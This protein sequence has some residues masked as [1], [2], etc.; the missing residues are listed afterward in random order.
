MKILGLDLGQKTLGIAISDRLLI[1][2]YGR[3]TVRFPR[4]DFSLA[5]ERVQELVKEEDVGEIALGLPLHLSG[6]VSPMAEFVLSFKDA[7]R[8][9]LPTVKIELVDERYTTLIAQRRLLESNMAS[10]RRR[11]IIDAEAAME[12]LETY[13]RKRQK[14]KT[15]AEG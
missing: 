6:D 7:L 8:E 9:A 10:K 11:D 13:L 14:E 5:I 2:A 3:E 4:R 12:I 1:G 15:D